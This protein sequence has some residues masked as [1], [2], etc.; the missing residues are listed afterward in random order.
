MG[1]IKGQ[2]PVTD[3]DREAVRELHAQSLG[4]NEIARRLNRSPRT[5]S[6]IA[7][8]LHLTFDTTM[9]EDATR[10]RVA[11]LAEKRAILAD[12][13]TDDALRLSA[14]L[15]QPATIYNFGGKDNTYEEKQVDEPPASDKRQL[16]TAATAAAAQSLRLVPPS[17]DGGAEQA[18]SMVGQLLTGLA[19]VYR[20]QQTQEPASEGDG[21]AP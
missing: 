6:V 3:E 12:A 4:R 10:A 1:L 17:E 20:E 2:R 9:T 14:Q 18:R 13:L 8:E 15:W 7:A 5:I 19:S 16:I 21:D 11:Q